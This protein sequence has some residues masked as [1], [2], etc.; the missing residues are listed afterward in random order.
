MPVLFDARAGR[1]LDTKS[2]NA[3][4]EVQNAGV[5]QLAERLLP[6]Q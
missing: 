5:A 2:H 4:N 6:K 3:Y 1:N